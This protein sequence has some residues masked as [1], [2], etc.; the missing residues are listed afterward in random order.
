MRDRT[1]TG[2]LK[3]NKTK[4]NKK[5]CNARTPVTQGRLPRFY[6]KILK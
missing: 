3:N 1:V 2:T 4:Q 6:L 5:F